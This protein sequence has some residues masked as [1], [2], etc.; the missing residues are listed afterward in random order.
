MKR[1]WSQLAD[2]L[3]VLWAGLLPLQTRW[4]LHT[5]QLA[6]GTWEY[7][8][9]SLYATD[10]LLMAAIL[11]AVFMNRSG[12]GG[13]RT[14]LPRSVTVG[15]VIITLGIAFSSINALDVGVALGWTLRAALGLATWWLLA[16]HRTPI[17]WFA[18]AIIISASIESVLIIWQFVAQSV[19]ASAL[20]GL[21][22]HASSVAGDAV[23]ETDLGRFLR[24]YGTLP[25]PNIAAGWLAVGLTFITGLYLRSKDAFER[26]ILLMGF[27]LVSVGLFLTFS[28]GGLLAWFTVFIC[29]VA[30]V[31]FRERSE[32]ASHWH[33]GF[34][35]AHPSPGM[36]MMKLVAVALLL[37]GVF[38]FA[39]A[40]LVRG[41]TDAVNRLEAKSVNE[42]VSQIDETRTL[43]RDHW[44]F[45]VGVG[46]YT[47]AVHDRID[48]SRSVW[49]YQPIHNIPL[50]IAAE[51]GI[52]GTVLLIWYAGMI[53]RTIFRVARQT[54]FHGHAHELPWSVIAGLALLL[55]FLISLV[56]HY[57]W[58][59][60]FGIM[61]FWLVFGLWAKSLRSD[62]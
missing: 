29:F 3:F 26:A 46:N 50:L 30:L 44:L 14:F 28:R 12:S 16:R 4:F 59:L 13:K 9:L 61:L 49:G 53:A 48:A 36:K 27:S 56:D 55:L 25:H 7:G 31:L 19:P 18:V 38:L 62:D 42:R 45:G 58:S 23:V 33:I 24:G 2:L 34:Q 5:G 37:F 32:T 41:R 39:F 10:I 21:A 43:V 22:R 11:L 15:A 35:R 20:F 40:P 1:R 8:T 60:P 57:L 54:W 6:G 47:K 52:F 17:A 51:L